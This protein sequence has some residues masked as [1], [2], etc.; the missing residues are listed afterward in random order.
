MY[1][2]TIVVK[3]LQI[4]DL[5]EKSS[6][7]PQSHYFHKE[8]LL[9]WLV[10]NRLDFIS[11]LL[12]HWNV[13]VPETTAEIVDLFSR[14]LYGVPRTGSD[15]FSLRGIPNPTF[16]LQS[17]SRVIG[18]NSWKYDRVRSNLL[19]ERHVP[20]FPLSVVPDFSISI[21]KQAKKLEL[22]YVHPCRYMNWIQFIDESDNRYKWR[23]MPASHTE[24]HSNYYD[25]PRSTLDGTGI[26]GNYSPLISYGNLEEWI[27]YSIEELEESVKRNKLPLSYY[28]RDFYEPEHSAIRE[29]YSFLCKLEGSIYYKYVSDLQEYCKKINLVASSIT[30]CPDVNNIKLLNVLANRLYD[31]EVNLEIIP[32][33][34]ESQFEGLKSFTNHPQFTMLQSPLIEIYRKTLRGMF[35]C[36]DFAEIVLTTTQTYAELFQIEIECREKKTQRAHIDYH[37]RLL[38]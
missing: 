29:L 14:T 20:N 2:T 16:S 30:F 28:Q 22:N 34:E 12:C 1:C 36:A 24:S 13:I 9:E 25:S 10:D 7:E 18:P 8:D 17:M 19:K 4:F 38:L 37:G 6:K 33:F 5:P 23:F 32:Q 3:R 21:S 27:V 15:S 11:T 26:N 31:R 35:C